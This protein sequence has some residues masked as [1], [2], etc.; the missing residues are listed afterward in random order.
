MVVCEADENNLVYLVCASAS[1]FFYGIKL[2][3]MGFSW[4]NL[5]GAAHIFVPNARRDWSNS[6][7]YFVS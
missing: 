1:R 3:L 7:V 6:A 2:R 4:Q 5:I